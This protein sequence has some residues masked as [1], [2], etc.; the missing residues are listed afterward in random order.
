MKKESGPLIL[1]KTKAPSHRHP[2]QGIG[3]LALFYHFGEGR[4]IALQVKTNQCVCDD[5]MVRVGCSQLEKLRSFWSARIPQ[6]FDCV[7][8]HTHIAGQHLAL[9]QRFVRAKFTKQLYGTGLDP[10]IFMQTESS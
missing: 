6:S 4:W 8:S 9:N 2:N 10:R 5:S 7:S 1:D 3:T